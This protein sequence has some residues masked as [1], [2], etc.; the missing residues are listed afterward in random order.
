MLLEKGR[1]HSIY[2]SQFIEDFVSSIAT[3]TRVRQL[4]S[5]R[6]NYKTPNPNPSHPYV[7]LLKRKSNTVEKKTN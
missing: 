1:V 5:K 4:A 2:K 7:C 3:N 6:I